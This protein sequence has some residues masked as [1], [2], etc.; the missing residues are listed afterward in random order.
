MPRSREE[1]L[2]KQAACQKALRVRRIEEQLQQEASLQ[3][4]LRRIDLATVYLSDVERK[5]ANR[6]KL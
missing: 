4:A 6:W 2:A 3:E 5:G 1:R